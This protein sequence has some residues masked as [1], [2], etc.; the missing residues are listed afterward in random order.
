[1]TTTNPYTVATLMHFGQ[2]FI[3][4]VLFSSIETRCC[5]ELQEAAATR[6]KKVQARSGRYLQPTGNV[7]SSIRNSPTRLTFEGLYALTAPADRK[8][9][10]GHLINLLSAMNHMEDIS[11]ERSARR[12]GN[13]AFGNAYLT[14]VRITDTR[15]RV[16][17]DGI[18][19]LNGI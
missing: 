9:L 6:P 12:A 8:A 10:E 1:V 5:L 19:E 17:L 18:M 13:M 2:W 16:I 7:A 15:T 11:H 14:Q 3:P 4:T